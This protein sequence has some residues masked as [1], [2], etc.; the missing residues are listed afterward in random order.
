[1][2]SVLADSRGFLWFCTG[3]GLSR[4]DGHLFTA[5]GV[6]E[7]LP[8][9]VI[10][11]VLE[12]S[13][14]EY[15]VATNGGGVARFHHSRSP[16]LP[17]AERAPA[18]IASRFTPIT[19]GDRPES[20]RVNVL[21]EDRAGRL[22]AGTDGG[23]FQLD[24]G[25]TP[26]FRPVALGLPTGPDRAVLVWALA[27]DT[28]GDLWVG[29]SWGLTRRV[30][31]GHAI[32]YAVEPVQGADHV[33]ALI[34]DPDDRI[35]I[36]HETGVIAFTPE[37]ARSQPEL[38]TQLQ[39]VRLRFVTGNVQSGD[40]IRYPSADG[41]ARG[42]IRSLYR[43]KDG[44]LWIGSLDGLSWFDGQRFESVTRGGGA[45][46]TLSITEDR[47]G[48]LWTGTSA[49]GAAKIAR[50][51]F[52]NFTEADGLGRGSVGELILDSAGTIYV[53]TGGQFIHRFDGT[54]FS[55]VRP[56]LSDDRSDS[57]GL[58]IALLDHTG[59]WWLP[60]NRGVLRFPRVA[61][62]EDL[63]RVPAKAVYTTDDGLAGEDVHR[64]FEDSRGDIWLGR[65]IPTSLVLTKWERKTGSFRRYS[66]S[67]GLPAFN[68]TQ[69]IAEDRAGNVW[70]G[71]RN[72]GLA[73]YRGG[74]FS[75]FTSTDGVPP[76]VITSLYLDTRGR[77][78]VASS[79]GGARLVDAPGE[80]RPQFVSYTTA[81]GLSSNSV[82]CIT[83]DQA[84]RIY[85]GV[86][87]GLDRLDPESGHV[88][89]F[90]AAEGFGGSPHAALRDRDGALWFATLQGLTRLIPQP[91]RSATAPA[92]FV[93]GVRIAGE[94]YYVSELGEREVRVRD[95]GPGQSRI[96]IDFFGL[97]SSPG[98]RYQYKLEPADPHWSES[99]EQ[100][101]VHYASLSPGGYRFLVRAVSSE[102]VVSPSA[103]TVSF[104]ILPPL[105]QRWWF[106]VLLAAGAA[107]LTHAIY[108]YR[109]VRALELERVRTRIATDLHDDVGA[110]LSQIAILSEVARA[111]VGTGA[112]AV[113]APLSRIADLSRESV[114]AMSEIV[115]AIDPQQDRFTDL[116]T[117]IRRLA[118]E[119]LPPRGIEL[120][121][122]ASGDTNIAVGADVRRE[123]FLVV[124]EA[125]NNIV[126]H[127]HCGAVEVGL[128]IDGPRL[129]LAI[130]D[131]GRGF[132]PQHGEA[133]NGLKSMRYRVSSLGGAIEISSG[134]GQGT[135]VVLTVPCRPSLRVERRPG[136][137][138]GSRPA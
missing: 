133:G 34:V 78:W 10:T 92:V 51:G 135:R 47:D 99:T 122:R 15:W 28:K 79:E 38:S 81:N 44:L 100:R 88:R 136:E 118:N 112:A 132:T 56:N 87:R 73:R 31:G 8:N 61:R 97:G 35:W 74:G 2:H 93:G 75:L 126:R 36:G 84:G 116:T 137:K 125:L 102:R 94:S 105:W 106:L 54:R 9:P 21:F 76:G 68:R 58:A 107:V 37:P 65:R 77:L 12:T 131:D 104:T 113:E 42:S 59:E 48:N 69:A 24:D 60:G 40:A 45:T 86:P 23:L 62:L 124:K 19:I 123:V 134:P 115:W 4:F 101:S 5:Y 64:L 111:R 127:A 18:A 53:V 43:S 103:A 6:A 119:M 121:F 49:A 22:W 128:S 3:Q 25:P 50:Y 55:K 130:N 120:Q 41:L 27:E 109:L 46:G 89:H 17:T 7:G 110:N 16:D 39:M 95:L 138:R 11:D 63:A 20:N 114:D 80:D 72:G 91:D 67:N 33:R 13:R 83:G 26:A 1:V 70:I 30:R 117:R 96:Q 14:G 71:F 66:D 98:L 29:S 32:H 82:T 52:S 57:A 90:T 108:R 85:F 129:L